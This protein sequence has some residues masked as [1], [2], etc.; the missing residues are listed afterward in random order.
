V[1]REPVAVRLPTRPEGPAA[2]RPPEARGLERDEI[3][4]MVAEPGRVAHVRF[5]EIGRFLNP[6]D[7]LVVNTSG[8]L[9]AAI[10]GTRAGDRPVVVHFS[11]N[12]GDGTWVVEL[13]LPDA[14]GPVLDGAAGESVQLAGGGRLKILHAYRGVEGKSRLL[15]ARPLLGLGVRGSRDGTVEHLARYGRPIT[16]G[17]LDGRWPL[18]MYQT[19]FANEPGS[20]E[21]PSAGR[22]FTSGLVTKLVGQGVMFAPILLHSGVSSPEKGEAPGPERF[23][24][25]E[26]TA[27]LVNHTRSSGGRVIA[28]GTTVTRALESATDQQG[29]VVGLEGWTDLLLD[30]SRPTRVVDGLCTG[31]HSAGAS[32]L[33]LL[34]AVAGRQ[35]VHRAYHEAAT[36]GYLWHEF[37]DSCL[38][39]PPPA[40]GA[41]DAGS[42]DSVGDRQKRLATARG[43]S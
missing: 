9:P 43:P 26:S 22:P 35:M 14:S 24:V 10:D 27:H 16:Y 11:T 5:R 29:Q 13:R 19:V 33:M 34:E 36:A 38:L 37:G 20:A 31:W 39:L 6:G 40:T 23:R 18:A 28:V 2:T 25:S 3:R 41:I 42:T 32:H 8:T 4:L 21:M 12:L 15:R 7:L 1:S 30:S 17:Y